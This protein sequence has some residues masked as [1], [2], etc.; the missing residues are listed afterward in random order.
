MACLHVYSLLSKGDVPIQLD[1]E[2]GRPIFVGF[3]PDCYF[4]RSVW[5]PA[6]FLDLEQSRKLSQWSPDDRRRETV[7]P[8][9]DFILK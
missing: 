3:L 4:S 1:S 8:P 2:D 9:A 7:W 6:D 5:S